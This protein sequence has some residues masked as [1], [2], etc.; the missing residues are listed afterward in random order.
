M[1]YYRLLVRSQFVRILAHR[2]AVIEWL[3]NQAGVNLVESAF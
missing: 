1:L 2:R 3:F